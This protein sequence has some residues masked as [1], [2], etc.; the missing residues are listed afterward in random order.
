MISQE[1]EKFYQQVRIEQTGP[2]VAKLRSRLEELVIQ[3]FPRNHNGF[4]PAQVEAMEKTLLR[5]AHRIAH[6]MIMKIKDREADTD[7]RTQTID[8]LREIFG[9]EDEEP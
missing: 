9:L 1:V 6:P 5:A 3:D 2:V 8:L 4:S 7:T